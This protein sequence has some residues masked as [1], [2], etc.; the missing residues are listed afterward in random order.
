MANETT[1][2]IYFM[3][4]VV[5]IVPP[6]KQIRRDLSLGIFYGTKIIVFDLNG[7]DQSLHSQVVCT[8]ANCARNENSRS[9]HL[10]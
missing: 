3:N 2:V 5:R 9:P 1:Q 6:N 10:P 8:N 7:A 4:E